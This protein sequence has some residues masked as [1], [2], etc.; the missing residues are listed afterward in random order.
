MKNKIFNDPIYGLIKFPYPILYKIIEHPSFQ[1]LRRIAQMGMASMVYT[2]V[3]HTR[4]A[5]ALGA[6][7]L[8]MRAIQSLKS[9]GVDISNEEAE[10]ACVAILCHD[11]GH[12]PFSHAL[13]F[14]LLPQHHEQ[15]TLE[16]M[17]SLALEFGEPIELAIQIFTG[18]YHKT[19]LHELVSSQ[20]D[21]DRLDYLARDSF[22]SGVA[23]G[24][25]GTSRIIEMLDVV[26]N[27]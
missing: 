4:F 23:E 15:L 1:R 27:R 17:K 20:L 9:K 11:M 19:F 25:V 8:M 2:G 13:D 7:H 26:D 6:T 16:M 12:G 22:Y 14:Q 10:A 18:H 21:V 3:N 5:H 24:V